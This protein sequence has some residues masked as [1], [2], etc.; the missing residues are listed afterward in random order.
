MVFSSSI[1]LFFFLPLVL[2]IYYLLRTRTQRNVFLTIM[3]LLFYAWGAPWF[4]LVMM[5]S[6]TANWFFGLHVD[7]SHPMPERKTW[8]TI[9]VIFNLALLGVFK[10]LNFITQNFVMLGWMREYTQIMLPIGISFFTFQAMSYV[11]DVYRGSGKS[12][13]SLMAVCLYIS[14]FPQL[15]A[16]PI[17]R[18][19]T[20]AEQIDHRQERLSDFTAGARRFLMGLAKKVLLAN[21]LAL[22][23]DHSFKLPASELSVGVAWMSAI[24]FHV[25]V[26][27]DFSGY[28]DMAIGMGKMFGFHFLENFNYPMVAK[29]VSDFWRRWHLSL[30]TWFRDYVFFP[31]GG[32]RVKSKWR[33]IFNMLV[34]WSLTGLWHGPDWC[35]FAWGVAFAALLIIERLT[36]LGKWMEKHWIGYL[37]SNVMVVVVTVLLG[38]AMHYNLDTTMPMVPIT[39]ALHRIGAM[40]GAGAA[41]LWD[42]TASMYVREY[43]VFMAA[44]ILFSLPF[45]PWLEKKLRIPAAVSEVARAVGLLLALVASLSYVTMGAFNPFIYFNF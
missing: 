18:Y 6:I 26:F 10:Y 16:G 22:M 24:F 43:G 25:Q 35:F 39:D 34:V 41:G 15:I 19:E 9:S 38:T 45:G 7:D 40:F 20:I 8:V 4:V 42:A 14:F 11:I 5:G 28:S 2:I 29:S 1:F 31:M 23:V 17:V 13:K 37:Y 21:N 32:S 44:S 12:Q 36:G 3:S 27:F 33:L 30:S